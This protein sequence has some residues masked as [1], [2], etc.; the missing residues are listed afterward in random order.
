MHHGWAAAYF[1]LIHGIKKAAKKTKKMKRMIQT[2]W[3]WLDLC[4]LFCF[5]IKGSRNNE[6]ACVIMKYLL[7]LGSRSRHKNTAGRFVVGFFVF[8]ELR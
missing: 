2:K 8:L 3:L 5:L 6:V 4:V 7:G 1:I